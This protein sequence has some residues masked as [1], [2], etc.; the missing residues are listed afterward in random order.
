[1]SDFE[2]EERLS[3]QQAAERLADIAYALA[4]GVTLELR[5]TCEQVPV[6]V[7]VTDEVVLRRRTASDGDRVDVEVQLSWTARGHDADHPEP[8]MTDHL[9]APEPGRRHPTSTRGG[10]HG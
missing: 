6:N 10:P 4:A 7:P 2:R 1:M 5:A 3:R 8:V 9:V